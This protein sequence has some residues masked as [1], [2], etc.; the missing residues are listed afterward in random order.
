[1]AESKSRTLLF[2]LAWMH[3]LALASSQA[4]GNEQSQDTDE[5][6]AEAVGGKHPPPP[7]LHTVPL[8]QLPPVS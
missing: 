5:V 6:E 1:M 8:Y 7:Y 3:L 4:G 2:A